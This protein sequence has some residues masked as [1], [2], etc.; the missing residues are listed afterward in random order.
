MEALRPS[1]RIVYFF[2][3]L[4]G[5]LSDRLG[6]RQLI[7]IAAIVFTAGSL[8]AAIAP[9]VAVLIAARIV[10]GLGVGSAVLMVPL[11]LSEVAPADVRGAVSSLNQLMRQRHPCRF[12][13]Q[14]DPRLLG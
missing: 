4:A 10:I 8:L 14:R 5:R 7:F 1:G 2:V 3:A 12:H 9:T 6:R 13:R 11:D